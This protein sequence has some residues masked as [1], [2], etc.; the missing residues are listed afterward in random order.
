MISFTTDKEFVRKARAVALRAREDGISKQPVI[1]I[2]MDLQ[3]THANGCPLDLD[4]LLSFDRFNFTHDVL[5]IERH[6][7]RR[8]DSPTGG[9]LLNHFLPRCARREIVVA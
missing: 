2:C 6:L 4:K 3:A 8:D 7:D 5:G 1:H 9:K